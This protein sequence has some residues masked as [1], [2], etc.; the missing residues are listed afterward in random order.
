MTHATA[1]NATSPGAS[2]LSAG[3]VWL[4]SRLGTIS[5]RAMSSPGA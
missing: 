4:R 1:D 3:F 5:L 2:A